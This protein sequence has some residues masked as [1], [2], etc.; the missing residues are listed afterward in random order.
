MGRRNFGA[1]DLSY[2]SLGTSLDLLPGVLRD[3]TSSS[4]DSMALMDNRRLDARNLKAQM[5]GHIS[6]CPG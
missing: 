2:S 4:M 5:L 3:L 1:H 6:Y